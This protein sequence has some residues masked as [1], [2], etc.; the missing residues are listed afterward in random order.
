LGKSTTSRIIINTSKLKFLSGNL[1]EFLSIG[2][3]LKSKEQ[4]QGDFLFCLCPKQE[5]HVA[6][7]LREMGSA[8]GKG[9]REGQAPQA[10]RE[11]SSQHPARK[12]ATWSSKKKEGRV[13]R[14]E[15]EP[16]CTE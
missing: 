11:I 16:A 1:S 5:W 14:D 3:A 15:E 10:R 7:D 2:N 13:G 9:V 6:W 4:C 12:E 8:Q